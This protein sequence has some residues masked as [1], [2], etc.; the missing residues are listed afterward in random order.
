MNQFIFIS[1]CLILA[2]IPSLD[3]FSR[4]YFEIPVLKKKM[5]SSCNVIILPQG[6]IMTVEMI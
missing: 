2:D 5:Q 1:S 6:D 3:E 4:N